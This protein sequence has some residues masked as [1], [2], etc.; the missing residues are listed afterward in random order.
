MERVE[1]EVDAATARY[2]R[3]CARQRGGSMAEAAAR[4]LKEVA[5]RAL[6][7]SVASHAGWAASVPSYFED[8]EAERTTALSA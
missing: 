7:D 2:L 6:A 5:E 8:A 4:Q 3:A 1:V